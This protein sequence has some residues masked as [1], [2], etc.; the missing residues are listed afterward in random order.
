MQIYKPHFFKRINA[1]IYVTVY[2]NQTVP[3]LFYFISHSNTTNSLL[4]NE[5]LWNKYIERDATITADAYCEILSKTTQNKRHGKM[6]KGVNFLHDNSRPYTSAN[7]RNN[8]FS[9][10]SIETI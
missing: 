5:V 10:F 6:L 1:R 9:R 2:Q 4:E 8:R 3:V 7:T